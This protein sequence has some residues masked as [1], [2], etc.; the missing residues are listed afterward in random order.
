[1]PVKRP[2]RLGERWNKKIHLNR[3]LIPEEK[4]SPINRKASKINQKIG[5]KEFIRE[6]GI[7]KGI[8]DIFNG[9]ILNGRHDLPPGEYSDLIRNNI[10]KR[11][12]LREGTSLEFYRIEKEY[13]AKVSKQEG[14]IDQKKNIVFFITDKTTIQ[15][16]EP[17]MKIR[18][19]KR[20]S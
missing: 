2:V 12:N 9:K 4:A 14:S 18:E 10:R 8:Q 17:L 3:R 1:M 16:L 5:G 7:R 20:K 13:Y 11:M 15:E 6:N 19:K